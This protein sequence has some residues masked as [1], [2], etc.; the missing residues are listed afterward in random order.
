MDVDY[1]EEELIHRIIEHF[2][3]EVRH[4]LLGHD[5]ANKEVLFRIFSDFDF[6]KERVVKQSSQRT[7]N[8]ASHSSAHQRPTHVNGRDVE[9][10]KSPEGKK[11]LE[12]KKL[13]CST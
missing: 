7:A 1:S 12:N 9:M 10:T 11:D 13:H 8:G 5:V 2:E 6:D 4:A 3:K